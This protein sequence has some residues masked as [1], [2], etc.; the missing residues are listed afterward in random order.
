MSLY[1]KFIW[2]TFATML[3]SS[4]IAFFGMNA[5]YHSHLKEQN[6]DKNM[7]IALSFADF[8]DGE[9]TERAQ[10]T[11]TMLGDAGYQ[12]YVTNG[13]S[14]ERFGG[15][16]R[17]ESIDLANIQQVLAGESFNGIREFLAKRSL[18]VF[19]PMN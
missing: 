11:L 2:F 7:A 18:L 14:V 9:S 16:Y 12:L 5:Y 15:D 4:S 19:L 1:V 6:N 13:D 3:V 17:D 8:L 10:A